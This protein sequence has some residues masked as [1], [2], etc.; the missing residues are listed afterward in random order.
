M[1]SKSHSASVYGHGFPPFG[2]GF[3]QVNFLG[4]LE[5]SLETQFYKKRKSHNN[6]DLADKHHEG[7]PVQAKHPKFCSLAAS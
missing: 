1:V 2:R 4:D 6:G 7:L 3:V 5:A